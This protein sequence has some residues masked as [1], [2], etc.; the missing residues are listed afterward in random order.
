MVR[1]RQVQW[2]FI[3]ERFRVQ[4]LGDSLVH[5]PAK[6]SSPTIGRKSYSMQL[7]LGIVTVDA[8]TP[9]AIGQHVERS[10]EC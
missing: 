4:P 3:V 7:V 2:Y 5:D 6:A 9:G 10:V 8:H 1:S